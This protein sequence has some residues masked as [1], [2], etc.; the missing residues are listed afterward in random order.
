M[1][2]PEKTGWYWWKAPESGFWEIVYYQAG[3]IY[4]NA[5]VVAATYTASLI[6]DLDGGEWGS[7]LMP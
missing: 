3:K 1:S 7:F 2:K 6:Q 4:R 5:F